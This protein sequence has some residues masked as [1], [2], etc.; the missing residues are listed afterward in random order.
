M[1]PLITLYCCH[2]SV[3]LITDLIPTLRNLIKDRIGNEG[4]HIILHL[5]YA[6]YHVVTDRMHVNPFI[7]IIELF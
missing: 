2:G 1:L 4:P 6:S 3:F 5:L 7:F